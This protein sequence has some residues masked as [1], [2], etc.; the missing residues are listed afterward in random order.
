MPNIAHNAI[1]RS[2]Y[3]N[4]FQYQEDG[5]LDKTHIRFFTMDSLE[6]LIKECGLNVCSR[7]ATYYNDE[8]TGILDA[9]DEA[10]NEL[11]M[12]LQHRPYANVYQF[13]YTLCKEP[14]D[15]IN[16]VNEIKKWYSENRIKLYIDLG[17]GFLEEN[18]FEAEISIG[19]KIVLE[20]PIDK[21]EHIKN[22]RIDP[23]DTSCI[24]QLDE[25]IIEDNEGNVEKIDNMGSN[26]LCNFNNVYIFESN[27]PQFII[28]NINKFIKSIRISVE[29]LSINTM[30]MHLFS[31]LSKGLGNLISE[32]DEAKNQISQLKDKIKYAT[33]ES[34]ER[35]IRIAELSNRIDAMKTEMQQKED[36]SEE[37]ATRI[38]E[39][40][41]MVD[42]MQIESKQ[43]AEKV[44][45]L[46][47][48]IDCMQ[49]DIV[50]KEQQIFLKNLELIKYQDFKL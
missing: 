38:A 49:A 22:I 33:I 14:R 6:T 17:L 31:I 37:R 15:E 28:Y 40:C 1:I 35:A 42:N 48:K 25:I 12:A 18:A 47:C 9:G 13:I 10:D 16:C 19:K 43:R 41:S 26:A 32:R 36:E 50:Q 20:F 2:L 7:L 45:E 8:M 27:D 21:I 44:S 39:L 30:Q 34:E 11:Q 29:L 24:C 5:I 4:K 46:S 3:A 23:I